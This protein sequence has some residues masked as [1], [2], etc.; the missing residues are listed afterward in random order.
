M[1]QYREL[2]VHNLPFDMSGYWVS[3]YHE[4]AVYNLPFHTDIDPEEGMVISVGEWVRRESGLA[5]RSPAVL[6]TFCT[7]TMPGSSLACL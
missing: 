2:T 1:S 6:R 4:L 3:Q 7:P 5:P